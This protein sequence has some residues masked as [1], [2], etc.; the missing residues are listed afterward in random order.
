MN[1]EDMAKQ[2][3]MQLVN[4]QKRKQKR[5]INYNRTNYLKS[6]AKASAKAYS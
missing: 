6:Q 4:M 3:N 2:Q 1:M 5:H